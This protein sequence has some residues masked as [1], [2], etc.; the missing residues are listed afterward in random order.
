MADI[1]WGA[2]PAY[3][4]GVGTAAA[5]L[6]AAESA[7]RA[8]KNS[9]EGA[10]RRVWISAELMLAKPENV[11]ETRKLLSEASVVVHN[12]SDEAIFDIAPYLLKG[13]WHA[14]TPERVNDWII[15]V[16]S[17]HHCSKPIDVA[18]WEENDDPWVS[19]I[20]M[21]SLNPPLGVWFTDAQGRAWLRDPHGRL[22]R[23]RKWPWQRI[24]RRLR[25]LGFSRPRQ[26]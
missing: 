26:R 9:T 6:L 8:V 15:R 3:I 14:G 23:L 17:P 4:G 12:D 20:G 5:F 25:K 16:I 18:W 2:V 19:V 7:R 11:D 24:P 10:A 13:G 22:Q 1:D 21:R